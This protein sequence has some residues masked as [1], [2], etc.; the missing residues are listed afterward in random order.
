MKKMKILL[1]GAVTLSK[2]TFSIMTLSK[3]TFSIMALSITVKKL[4]TKYN[5][6]SALA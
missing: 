2:M 1:M 3:M 4:N 6:D 5:K